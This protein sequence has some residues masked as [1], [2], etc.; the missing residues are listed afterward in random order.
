MINE[1]ISLEGNTSLYLHDVNNCVLDYIETIS[2]FMCALDYA[3]ATDKHYRRL[4]NTGSYL[5]EEL[6]QISQKLTN[7]IYKHDRQD[8]IQRGL[9]PK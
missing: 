2:Q 6:V 9:I 8:N 1:L 4:T 3:D 7:Q 5:T